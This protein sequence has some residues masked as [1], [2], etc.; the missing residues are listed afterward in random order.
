MD[1][2]EARENLLD[3]L[4]EQLSDDELRAVD[5]HLARCYFCMEELDDL[6][7]TLN[8]CRSA[9]QHPNPAGRFQQLRE[10]LA[11]IE[12]QPTLAL[13]KPKQRAAG[14]FKKL[15]VATGIILMIGTSPIVIQRTRLFVNSVQKNTGLT[16]ESEWEQWRFQFTR[17][18]VERRVEIEKHQQVARVM[19]R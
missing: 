7:R 6:D 9:I 15:A 13:L 3:Y 4:S 14:F 2:P 10:R 16:A 1:C 12:L 8:L 18:F 11:D 19:E 17:P 5:L